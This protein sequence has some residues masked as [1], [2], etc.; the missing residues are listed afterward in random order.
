MD[1]T[2][3]YGLMV[4]L[5]LAT[6]CFVL[7]GGPKLVDNWFLRQTCDSERAMKVLI[8]LQARGK[9][10]QRKFE[11]AHRR[12]CE[13]FGVEM[14]NVERRI[15]LRDSI[16]ARRARVARRRPRQQRLRRSEAHTMFAGPAFRG[17]I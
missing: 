9:I 6:L 14:L 4:L 11:E 17:S 2:L 1:S 13:A 8:Q 15:K 7:L 12:I 10:A 3:F 5:A 16:D